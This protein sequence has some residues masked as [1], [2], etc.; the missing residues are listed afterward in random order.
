LR[1]T[2]FQF[3]AVLPWGQQPIEIDWHEVSTWC[4]EHFGLPGGRYVVDFNVN[5][6]TWWFRTHQD[7]LVFLL[8]NG[9]AQCLQPQVL[10]GFFDPAPGCGN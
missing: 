10:T 7:R 1:D 4:M 9:R 8:R 6:M 5:D 3:G 2:D